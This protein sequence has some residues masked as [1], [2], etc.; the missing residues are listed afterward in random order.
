[1]GDTPQRLANEASLRRRSG[2]SPATISSVAAWSVY[3]WPEGRSVPGPPLCHQ[4]VQ[5]P[6][7][8]GDLF[9]E[10]LVAAGHR[11]QC[12][13]SRPLHVSEIRDPGRKRAPTERQA[14]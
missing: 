10:S 9:G 1:M 2:L 5:V 6:I 7:E 13:L 4:P 8:F 11:A 14:P 3:Q 12:E